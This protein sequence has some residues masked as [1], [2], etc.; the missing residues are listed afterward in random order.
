MSYRAHLTKVTVKDLLNSYKINFIKTYNRRTNYLA[1]KI[2]L[3][4]FV[5]QL[6]DKEYLQRLYI[7]RINELSQKIEEENT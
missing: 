1:N 7:K 6:D 4:I 2:W 3:H 5:I